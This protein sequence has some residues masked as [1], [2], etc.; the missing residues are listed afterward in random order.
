M[1]IRERIDRIIV[2]TKWRILCNQAGVIHLPP[3][4][5]DHIPIQLSLKEDHPFI[6]RPFQFLEAWIRDPTC[7]KIIREAWHHRSWSNRRTSLS[8]RLSNTTK[9]LKSWNRESLEFCQS[10]I[11]SL[12]AQ[13]TQLFNSLPTE[14]NIIT[15][16]KVYSDIDE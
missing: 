11:K 6:P 5:S 4:N 7:E 8:A 3:E 1:N 13:L 2:S 14:E 12:E 15:Q 16:Q 9:A 10:K